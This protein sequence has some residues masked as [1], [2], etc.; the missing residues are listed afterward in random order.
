M[1]GF[2]VLW[3][4][5]LLGDGSKAQVFGLRAIAEQVQ[6]LRTRRGFGLL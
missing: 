4:P 6:L 5:N 3:E 1:M 2:G